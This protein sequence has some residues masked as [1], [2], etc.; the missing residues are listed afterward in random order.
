VAK[1]ETGKL[2]RA[3]ERAGYSI[4]RTGRGHLKI[5]HPAMAGPVFT[6]ST[7]SDR[8]AL[9]NATAML[10]RRIREAQAAA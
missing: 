10:K 4:A 2:C 9:A 8:R 3:L 6:G 7:P 1:R 5:E